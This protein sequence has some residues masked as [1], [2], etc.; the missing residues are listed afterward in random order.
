MR[1]TKSGPARKQALKPSDNRLEE[2][3]REVFQGDDQSSL[4]KDRIVEQPLPKKSYRTVTT[5]GAYEDPICSN[6]NAKLERCSQ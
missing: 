3:Y 1:A 4:W 5:Y 2:K 6:H